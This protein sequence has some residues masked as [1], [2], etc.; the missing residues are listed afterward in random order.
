MTWHPPQPHPSSQRSSPAVQ[1]IPKK[2]EVI[3]LVNIYRLHEL[4]SCATYR[5][6][7]ATSTAWA[8][9]QQ[10]LLITLGLCAAFRIDQRQKSPHTP[11]RCRRPIACIAAYAIRCTGGQE[12]NLVVA[13]PDAPLCNAEAEDMVQEGLALGMPLGSGE[14]LSQHLLQQLQ[15]RLLVKG[16]QQCTDF[17]SGMDS[18]IMKQSQRYIGCQL[19]DMLLQHQ[20]IIS[21]SRL[22]KPYRVEAQDRT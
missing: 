22:G 15:V 12:A 6:H 10:P 7:V 17:S 11:Q 4:S 18:N 19:L 5:K 13:Q 14:C 20:R 9:A 21:S 8:V 1:N 16:L 3:Y 2:E